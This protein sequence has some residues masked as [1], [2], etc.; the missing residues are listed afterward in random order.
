MKIHFVEYKEITVDH[1]YSA[2]LTWCVEFEIY[3]KN[4]GYYC[5]M[6]RK[7]GGYKIL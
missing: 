2:Y 3:D 1:A 7:N 4:F 5:D 6:L